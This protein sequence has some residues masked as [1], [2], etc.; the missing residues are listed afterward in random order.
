TALRSV[1]TVPRLTPLLQM[2][3]P[4]IVMAL[5]GTQSK[6]VSFIRLHIQKLGYPPSIREIQK[7][8]GFKSP[9][10]V[11]YQ[12][13]ALERMGLLARANKARA[14]KLVGSES[15]VPI[16]IYASIPAGAPQL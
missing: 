11:S 16:P 14:L 3:T 4:L 13:E 8:C 5:S 7:H 6:I 10:A 15:A 2:D 12:L 1:S 9:R